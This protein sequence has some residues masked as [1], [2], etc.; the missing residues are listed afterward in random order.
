MYYHVSKPLYNLEDKFKS[1][2]QSSFYVFLFF[3]QEITS[4][5]PFQSALNEIAVLLNPKR[6]DLRRS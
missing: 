5:P 3:S 1:P 4:R 2:S 6:F